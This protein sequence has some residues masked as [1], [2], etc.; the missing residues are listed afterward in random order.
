MEQR[1][2]WLVA[3]ATA[4][5]WSRAYSEWEGR[6]TYPLH[7]SFDL[8]ASTFASR[9]GLNDLYEVLGEIGFAIKC[10]EMREWETPHTTFY[11]LSAA[12]RIKNCQKVKC[13]LF[14]FRIIKVGK[15][16]WTGACPRLLVAR[17][18]IQKGGK[19]LEV[20]RFSL[21]WIPPLL[22]RRLS[23]LRFVRIF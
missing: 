10:H 17:A 22:W 6:E 15:T 21:F 19:S 1:A 5:E 23:H 7:I 8:S 9:G 13:C 11:S 2:A 12:I 4:F 3:N 14:F 18:T 16:I 20:R